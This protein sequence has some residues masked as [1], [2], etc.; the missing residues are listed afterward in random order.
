MANEVTLTIEPTAPKSTSIPRAA[1]IQLHVKLKNN[2]GDT[3][4]LDADSPCRSCSGCF[5]RRP[6]IVEAPQR[7]GDRVR[8]ISHP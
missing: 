6:R 5:D 8:R 4:S 7:K 3:V 2:T 1:E